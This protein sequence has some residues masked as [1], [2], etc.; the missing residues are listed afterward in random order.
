[1]RWMTWKMPVVFIC[2]VMASCSSTSGEASKQRDS[3]VELRRPDVELR[4]PDVATSVDGP[5]QALDWSEIK[6]QR[7]WADALVESACTTWH[8]F[9]SGNVKAVRGPVELTMGELS[10]VERATED[11]AFVDGMKHG[12]PKQQVFDASATLTVSTTDGKDWSQDV[13]LAALFDT[14]S[15]AL[16]AIIDVVDAA[17]LRSSPGCPAAPTICCCAFEGPVTPVCSHGAW[18]CSQDSF[19]GACCVQD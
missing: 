8:L 11:A 19:P 4:R 1:M 16:T 15:S 13:S 7:C 12:F 5:S 9:R 18:V 14:P 17:L 10:T 6:L 3:G 2:L